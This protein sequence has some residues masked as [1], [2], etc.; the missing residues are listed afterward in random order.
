MFGVKVCSIYFLLHLVHLGLRWKTR[1][2][3]RFKGWDLKIYKTFFFRFNY[4]FSPRIL[5]SSRNWSCLFQIEQN[6]PYT[7]TFF[8]ILVITSI[9]SLQKRWYGK[10]I[11]MWL[12]QQGKWHKHVIKTTFFNLKNQLKHFRNYNKKNWK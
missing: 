4:T 10:E 1:G 7:I 8:A 6:S 3:K 5:T 12:C 11:S 9:F 2:K